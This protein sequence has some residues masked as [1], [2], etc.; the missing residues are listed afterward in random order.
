MVLGA[1]IFTEQVTPIAERLNRAI[2]V[3]H[4]QAKPVYFLVSGGQGL[5][6]PITEALAMKRYLIAKGIPE[7]IILMENQSEYVYK[8]LI[9]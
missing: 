4:S 2:N 8:L 5:D 9:F 1:G 7:D 6:E 3:Y